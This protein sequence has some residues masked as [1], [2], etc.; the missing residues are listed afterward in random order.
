MHRLEA[1]DV[2][3]CGRKAKLAFNLKFQISSLVLFWYTRGRDAHYLAPATEVGF[4]N[5]KR[6]GVA[7]YELYTSWNYMG[8]LFSDLGNLLRTG[9][10]GPV[11]RDCGGA[12][13]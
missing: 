5:S 7:A 3:L 11:R 2:G 12:Y 13:R 4:E 10:G 1:E 6:E 9:S 8:Y